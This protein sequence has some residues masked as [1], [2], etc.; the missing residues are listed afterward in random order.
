MKKQSHSEWRLTQIVLTAL[1]GTFIAIFVVSGELNLTFA[2]GYLSVFALVVACNA[3]YVF[4][5]RKK[6]LKS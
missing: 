6:T 4:Y 3:I 2:I 1:L 5:K